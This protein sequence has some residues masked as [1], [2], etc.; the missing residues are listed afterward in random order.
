MVKRPA[1][2]MSVNFRLPPLPTVSSGGRYGEL[3]SG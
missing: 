3:E 1:K 2:F